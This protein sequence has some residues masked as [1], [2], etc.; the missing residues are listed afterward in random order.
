MLQ[1]MLYFIFQAIFKQVKEEKHPRPML[2]ITKP[3]IDN[4][5]ATTY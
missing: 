5:L 3:V 1:E 2:D 4:T